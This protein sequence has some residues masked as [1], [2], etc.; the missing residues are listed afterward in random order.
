MNTHIQIHT[1]C[2]LFITILTQLS[3]FNKI[4]IFLSLIVNY[5]IVNYLASVTFESKLTNKNTGLVYQKI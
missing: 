4:P 1:L 3:K 5:S 2:R